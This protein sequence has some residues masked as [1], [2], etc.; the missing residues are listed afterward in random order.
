[1]IITSNSKCNSKIN[2]SSETL[3]EEVR[4]GRKKRKRNTAEVEADLIEGLKSIEEDLTLD[5]KIDMI[6]R[7]DLMMTKDHLKEIKKGNSK[8]ILL[9]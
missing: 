5:L 3:K 8:L 1:M 6:E 2:I 4:K 9:I 7:E